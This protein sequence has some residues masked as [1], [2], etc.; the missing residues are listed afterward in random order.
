[1]KVKVVDKNLANFSDTELL[2]EL[3]QRNGFSGAPVKTQRHGGW[4]ECLVAIGIDETASICL[5]DTAMAYLH[6]SKFGK[7]VSQ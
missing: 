5:P 1:M 7:E 6:F 4:N 2:I 3:I